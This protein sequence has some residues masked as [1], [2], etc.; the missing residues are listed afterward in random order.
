MWASCP[1]GFRNLVR[2]YSLNRRVGFGQGKAS[3]TRSCGDSGRTI[4]TCHMVPP[5][6]RSRGAGSKAMIPNGEFVAPRESHTRM[7][8][9]VHHGG[10]VESRKKLWC[11][12]FTPRVLR[13]H[14]LCWAA[15]HICASVWFPLPVT[16]PF[17]GPHHQNTLVALTHPCC[18]RSAE[19]GHRSPS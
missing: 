8:T 5:R 18:Q 7:E 3:T 6:G 2:R 9:L 19:R 1:T 4:M 16:F 11:V 13:A 12:L 17:L 10:L 14:K 15:M